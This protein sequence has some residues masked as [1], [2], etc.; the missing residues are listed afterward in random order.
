MKQIKPTQLTHRINLGQLQELIYLIKVPEYKTL[1]NRLP[2]ENLSVSV[3]SVQG[4][5]F[6]SV[7]PDNIRIPCNNK[8][9]KI[10]NISDIRKEPIGDAVNF[11]KGTK[12]DTVTDVENVSLYKTP[13]SF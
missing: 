9:N 2:R 10:P 11:S 12:D 6:A 13:Q 5:I 8:R 4:G 3:L 1:R 7:T